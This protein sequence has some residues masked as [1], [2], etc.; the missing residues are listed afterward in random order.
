MYSE[1]MAYEGSA[2]ISATIPAPPNA[3]SATNLA[4]DNAR[5]LAFRV[6]DLV[7]RLCGTQPTE[8]QR[9]GKL[10]GSGSVL[11]SLR[12]DAERT[13]EAIHRAMSQLNRLDRELP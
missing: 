13:S 10:P 9:D 1:K 2:G 8:V 12:D 3:F 7:D 6:A 5:S 4:L 11:T